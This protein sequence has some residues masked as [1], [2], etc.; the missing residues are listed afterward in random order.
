VLSKSGLSA[1]GV[2]EGLSRGFQ[3]SM[4][5]AFE[6]AKPFRMHLQNRRFQARRD[7]CSGACLLRR[8]LLCIGLRNA[9]E[10]VK[11]YDPL[12]NLHSHS[13]STTSAY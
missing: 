6:L 13:V 12:L 8:L 9:M 7:T 5:R 4:T 1:G 2:Q 11:S 3:G 10:R